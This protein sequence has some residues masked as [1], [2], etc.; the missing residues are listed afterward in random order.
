MGRPLVLINS[1]AN[2]ERVV[3]GRIVP[4]IAQA[5]SESGITRMELWAEGKLVASQEAPASPRT[6]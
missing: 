5:R 3:F 6:M 2:G 1:P 4:A